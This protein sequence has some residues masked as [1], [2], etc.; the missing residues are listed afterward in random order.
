MNDIKF[1]EALVF[2]TAYG[3]LILFIVLYFISDYLNNVD[4]KLFNKKQYTFGS[5]G[6]T[7]ARK[8]NKTGEVQFVLWKAGEQGHK[9]DYWIRFDSSWWS[10]FKP[11][12]NDEKV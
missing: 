6:D 10:Q 7:P 8:N 12:I 11:E 5:I 9:E 3:I 4:F 1:L 2:S